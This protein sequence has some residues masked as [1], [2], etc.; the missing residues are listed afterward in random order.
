MFDILPF[1]GAASPH[2]SIWQTAGKPHLAETIILHFPGERHLLSRPD[3][4]ACGPDAISDLMGM[5]EAGED[6]DAREQRE[7][8]GFKLGAA[9]GVGF[10]TFSARRCFRSTRGLDANIGLMPGSSRRRRTRCWKYRRRRVVLSRWRRFIVKRRGVL[11]RGTAGCALAFTL[12]LTWA[13]RADALAVISKRGVI[14]RRCRHAAG[15][16]V[17]R[18]R[19]TRW[20]SARMRSLC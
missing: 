4:H 14:R 18:P 3:E 13:L 15:R 11:R 16:G 9:V 19:F 7:G 1:I 2:R 6:A 17:G 5:R 10:L 20:S 12:V 8:A